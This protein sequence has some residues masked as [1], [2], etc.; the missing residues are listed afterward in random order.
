MKIISDI[1]LFMFVMCD[2]CYK[3]SDWS[4][5][6]IIELPVLVFHYLIGCSAVPAYY[7]CINELI[8]LLR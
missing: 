2:S 3:F 5:L 8:N 4:M 6:L 1:P 7:L